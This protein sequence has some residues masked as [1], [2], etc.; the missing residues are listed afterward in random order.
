MRKF[1]TICHNNQYKDCGV[2]AEQRESERGGFLLA[3]SRPTSSG[4]LMQF[5]MG[6]TATTI[7]ISS[8]K[9]PLEVGKEYNVVAYDAAGHSGY[10]IVDT[11][12]SLIYLMTEDEMM[13]S[14]YDEE[15]IMGIRFSDFFYTEEQLREIKINKIL[16]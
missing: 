1:K 10:S 11:E 9:I 16:D 15:S 8:E 6:R 5:T 14:L 13:I 12:G 2:T 3:D 4:T 7:G